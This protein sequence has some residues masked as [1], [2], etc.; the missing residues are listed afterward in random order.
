MKG[1]GE[2]EG[3]V[4]RREEGR[5]GGKE[6]RGG[7]EGERERERERMRMNEYK[8]NNKSC[9]VYNQEEIAPNT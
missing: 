2:W 8:E 7:R 4:R 1:G 5:E 3:R 9:S 6:G